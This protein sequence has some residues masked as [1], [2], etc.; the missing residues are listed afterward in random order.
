[1][2][3]FK[4]FILVVAAIVS[5]TISFANMPEMKYEHLIAENSQVE[6]THPTSI[7]RSRI[8][9]SIASEVNEP[10]NRTKVLG[11]IFILSLPLF[12]GVWL[13]KKKGSDDR[14]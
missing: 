6:K 10:E 2:R 4:I 8:Q 9:R 11:Y 13:M 1:M 7:K 3:N 5:S 12:L 14:I